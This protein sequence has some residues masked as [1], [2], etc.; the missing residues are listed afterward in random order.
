MSIPIKLISVD[1]PEIEALKNLYQEIDQ[2]S[3][4]NLENIDTLRDGIQDTLESMYFSKTSA[5]QIDEMID[6][7]Q[8]DLQEKIGDEHQLLAV[9]SSSTLEDL[10][11]MAGAGL[12]D[13]ILNVK[14]DNTD[15]IKR[16]I[17]DVWLSLHTQRATISRKQNRI[18]TEHAQMGILIQRMID[19][20]MSFVIHSVNPMT[21]DPNQVY[22]E[23]AIGQGETL[24]S[25]S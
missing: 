2:C 20:Q 23:L 4:H 19:S 9:R 16:A 18:K 3:N 10:D 8:K 7:I 13:S 11:Q 14:L 22:M 21:D 24:A 1:F 6:H 12:F 15:A 25:A 5:K 17:I